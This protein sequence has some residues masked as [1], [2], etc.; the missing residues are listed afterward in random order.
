MPQMHKYVHALGDLTVRE[1]AGLRILN[2]ELQ[3]VEHW[4]REH[5]VRS[6]MACE[7]ATAA[8]PDMTEMPARHSQQEVAMTASVLCM[9][10]TSTLDRSAHNDK[11]VARLNAADVLERDGRHWYAQAT[12]SDDAAVLGLNPCG[13]FSMLFNQLKCDW[14]RMLDV[15]AL[16]VQMTAAATRDLDVARA[17]PGKD[18]LGC[19]RERTIARRRA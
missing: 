8:P 5:A 1:L 2:E 10:R 16:K 14:L 15:R 12:A 11:V 18:Y 3:Q 7:M 4:I 17:L 13:L 9:G 19:T 6:L